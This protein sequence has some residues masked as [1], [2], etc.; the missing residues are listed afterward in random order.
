MHGDSGDDEK[1][2]WDEQSGQ[3]MQKRNRDEV[4]GVI[5]KVVSR[6]VVVHDEKN[7]L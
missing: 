3:K 6:D 7:D 4:R 5:D 1:V 2:N